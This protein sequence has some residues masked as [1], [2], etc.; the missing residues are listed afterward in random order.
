MKKE[1]IS[2]THPEVVSDYWDYESNS[3]SP[4][5]VTHGSAKRAMWKCHK[6]HTWSAMVN[7]LTRGVRCPYCAG[8]RV[9]PGFND[10][11]TTHPRAAS[12]WDYSLNDDTPQDVTGRSGKVRH[13]VCPLGHKRKVAISTATSCGCRVCYEANHVGYG[14]TVIDRYPDIISKSWDFSKNTADPKDVLLANKD[15]HWWLCSKGHSWDSTVDSVCASGHG[16]PYCSGNRVL[17]GETDLATTHPEIIDNWWDHGKNTLDPTK[18]VSKGSNRKVWWKCSAGHSWSA[19]IKSVVIGGNRCK[20]CTGIILEPGVNDFAT[21]YPEILEMYHPV[22]GT[23]L[24]M[25]HRG[26]TS[27]KITWTCGKHEWVATVHSMGKGKKCP[28]CTSIEYTHPHLME[29]WSDNN[30]LP[31]HRYSHGSEE[32]V[33]WTCGKHTWSAG[34]YS[35]ANGSR[36]PHCRPK[37]SRKEIEVIDHIRNVIGYSGE[38]ST[39][40]REFTGRKSIDIYIPEHKLAIEY[41]GMYHHRYIKSRSKYRDKEKRDM[42]AAAGQKFMAIWDNDWTD[43]V[44]QKIISRALA[45]RLGMTSEKVYARNTEVTSISVP[46]AKEFLEQNHIQGYGVGGSIKYGLRD[47]QGNL[48]AVAVLSTSGDDLV[49]NRYATSLSVPGGH[50]KIIK[51]IEDNHQYRNIITFADLGVSDGGLYLATGWVEDGEID[52][53]YKYLYKNKPHHKFNFRKKRFRDD[54]NL[55]FD[56]SMTEFQLAELNDIH[57]VYD[58]GKIRF[59]KPHPRRDNETTS[60]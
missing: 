10:M 58:Y 49:L 5:E 32:S 26:N 16:C 60:N 57:R 13:F 28:G 24:G 8:K 42:V 48:V 43:P 11:G 46:E 34:V 25:V 2:I 14:M 54:P 17:P 22:D 52:P 33:E 38:I 4:D 31:P 15:K 55:L 23:D 41:N 29:L 53:D 6:G 44:K 47:R 12:E 30:P 3:F 40:N 18:D 51:H 35:V 50:S 27:R 37:F 20:S 9:L 7:V 1:P 19:D 39:Q 56:P 59:I 36:C 21:Q 45:H